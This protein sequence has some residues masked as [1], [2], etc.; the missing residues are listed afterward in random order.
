MLTHIQ[1][2][3]FRIHKST[4]INIVDT[5]SALVG[6]NDIGKSS[7]LEALDILCNSGKSIS[8][9]DKTQGGTAPANILCKLKNGTILDYSSPTIEDDRRAA[10]ISFYKFGVDDN[11]HFIDLNQDLNSLI[12]SCHQFVETIYPYHFDKKKVEDLL[13]IFINLGKLYSVTQSQP[14]KDFISGYMSG[15]RDLQKI[16]A[17]KWRLN[18]LCTNSDEKIILYTLFGILSQFEPNIQKVIKCSGLTKKAKQIIRQFKKTGDSNIFFNITERKLDEVAFLINDNDIRELENQPLFIYWVDEKNPEPVPDL[19]WENF[20]KLVKNTFLNGD[21]HINNIPFFIENQDLEDLFF[22]GSFEDISSKSTEILTRVDQ[23]IAS[24]RQKDIAFFWEEYLNSFGSMN[25][26]LSKRGSGFKRLCEIYYFTMSKLS[27]FSING[28][29]II[30]AVEEPEI[31]LH[32]S[33][34]RDIVNRLQDI[35]N[36]PNTQVIISTH[37]PFIVNELKISSITVLKRKKDSQGNEL[38][39]IE[40][41]PLN[42]RLLKKPLLCEIN[43]LAFKAAS[44]DYHIALFGLI[45]NLINTKFGFCDIEHIDSKCLKNEP[46]KSLTSFHTYFR[47]GKDEKLIV[48]KPAETDPLKKYVN[49]DYSLQYC[50]R[51]YIDHPH[52]INSDFG[53]MNI[54]ETSIK[55]MIN[56]ITALKKLPD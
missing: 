50:V 34:Q 2:T 24:D 27:E 45:I 30:L 43:Y 20:K 42:D 54:V 26:K 32:P 33:Q 16:I 39:E 38:D 44:Y 55:Q 36:L 25:I 8:E 3:N 7:V 15:N 13:N 28:G 12:N 6:K 11:N 53:K 19:D 29:P 9:D 56:I 35:L 22:E 10:N 4:D 5:F 18:S 31:S 21:R 49:D 51:N 37:S 48:R 40:P 17:N 41:N 47:T 46:F 52:E 14:I 1:L 23:F